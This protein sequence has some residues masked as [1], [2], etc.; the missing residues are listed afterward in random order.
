M[1][2]AMTCAGC[3][4]TMEEG[5]VID[6][7]HYSFPAEQQWVEGEPKRSFWTG[8]ET[9]GKRSF[10]VTTYRCERCGRLESYARESAS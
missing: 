6:H 9:D 7:G 1:A 5:F 3:G 10:N 8:L 4:G 2:E